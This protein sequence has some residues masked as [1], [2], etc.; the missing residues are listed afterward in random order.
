MMRA[1]AV[2][3]FAGLSACVSSPRPMA[4]SESGPVSVEL[5]GQSYIADLQPSEAGPV[6][7]VTRDGAAFGNFEGA[8]AKRAAEAFCGARG[9]S[10]NRAAYGHYVGGAWVFKG[11][12]A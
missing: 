8:E 6:L 11:G 2:I 12:C 5:A 10:V 7:A 3:G 4:L 1:V 9:R